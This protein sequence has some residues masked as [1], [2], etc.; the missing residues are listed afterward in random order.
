MNLRTKEA[1][2]SY[3][4]L[5]NAASGDLLNKGGHEDHLYSILI[6]P[7]KCSF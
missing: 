4:H 2:Y 6:L 1:S 7:K 5:K 3:D